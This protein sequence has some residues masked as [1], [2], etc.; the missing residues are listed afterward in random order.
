[1]QR[2]GSATETPVHHVD[3]A[4]PLHNLPGAQA[5]LE[6]KFPDDILVQRWS[7]GFFRKCLKTCKLYDYETHCWLGF[8]GGVTGAV[9]SVH[10][11]STRKER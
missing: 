6:S 8:D 5:E 4:V 3:M 1:M 10:R 2:D 9:A 7:V 11:V